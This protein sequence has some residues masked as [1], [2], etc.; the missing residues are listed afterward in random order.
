[1]ELGYPAKSKPFIGGGESQRTEAFEE[2]QSQSIWLRNCE[3]M[4]ALIDSLPPAQC[5]A[6][7]HIYAG[8]SWRFPRDNALKLLEKAAETLLLGMNARAVI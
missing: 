2:S 5:C 8:D 6:V 1:M 3:V 4:D 7:R